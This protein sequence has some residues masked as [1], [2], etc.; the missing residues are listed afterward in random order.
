MD[1]RLQIANIIEAGEPLTK[2]TI[3][4]GVGVTTAGDMRRNTEKI[5]KFSAASNRKLEKLRKTMKCENDEEL[6]N[7]FTNGL[8]RKGMKGCQYPG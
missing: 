1:Q 3:E 7:V 4:F 8:F 5:K 2:L 6:D